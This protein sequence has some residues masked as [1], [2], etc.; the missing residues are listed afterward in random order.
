MDL[1]NNLR[2]YIVSCVLPYI[3]TLV[4]YERLRPGRVT[5]ELD[6]NVRATKHRHAFFYMP[7]RS[8]GVGATLIHDLG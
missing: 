4:R 1:R 2:S 7:R 3:C 6:M 8:A 5:L